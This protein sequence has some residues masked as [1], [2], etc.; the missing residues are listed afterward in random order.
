MKKICEPV[1]NLIKAQ[2][3]CL[4]L[5]APLIGN[6][7]ERLDLEARYWAAQPRNDNDIIIATLSNFLSFYT[8][9]QKSLEQSHHLA[10]VPETWKLANDL[11]CIEQDLYLQQLLLKSPESLIGQIL[12]CFMAIAWALSDFVKE[13]ISS[14]FFGKQNERA[15]K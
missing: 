9:D 8:E 15:V 4:F 10:R 2:S 1:Q 11:N 12:E 13:K 7:Y 3:E 5:Y 14:L 6:N